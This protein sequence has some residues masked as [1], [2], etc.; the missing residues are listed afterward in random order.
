MSVSNRL[1]AATRRRPTRRG[2]RKRLTDSFERLRSSA[3]PIVQCALAAGL[4]WWVAKDL[5][6]HQQPFFAPI[7]AVVSLGLGLGARLRRSVELVCGVTVGI[8]VGDLLVSLIGSGPWQIALVVTIAMSTAVALNSGP[9][10]AMQAGNSAVLVATLLPP[11]GTGGPDRM[12]DALIGGLT[13]IA[14]VAMIPTH[15][16]RRARRNAAEV[17]ATASEVLRKVETGLVENNPKPIEDALKQARATQPAID[18]MR[19]HLKGGREISRISPLYWNSRGRLA[20]L[21]AA[22]DP[23]DHAMRN[24]RVLARRSLTLVRDDEILDP[25]LVQRFAEV[26]DAVDVLRAM[27]LAEPGEQPDQAEAARV[28]RSIAKKMDP[29]LI[30]GAGV[31]ATVVFAQMRSLIVD[32]LQTAGLKRITAI[33]TL[34]PTVEHPAYDPDE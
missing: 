17:L 23:I 24:I 2:A 5:V 26:A 19:T 18:T 14:V 21:T 15:P 28:L 12:V 3:L 27:V 29:D 20:V 7:A 16:V 31:S 1:S 9:I 13:G 11:G 8:G 30:A 22:A 4:A 25:R 6:G 33:A 32:L 34:P 10:F